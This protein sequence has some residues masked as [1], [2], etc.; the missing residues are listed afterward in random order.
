VNF[1]FAVCE[2]KIL[3][4]DFPAAVLGYQRIGFFEGS[5]ENIWEGNE[6]RRVKIPEGAAIVET[7]NQYVFVEELAGAFQ[8]IRSDLE[9]KPVLTIDKYKRDF[10]RLVT[11]PE[12]SFLSPA[13]VS[14]GQWALLWVAD[15]AEP[16]DDLFFDRIAIGP[17][18]TFHPLILSRE[19][20]LN[21]ERRFPGFPLTPVLPCN[22]EAGKAAVQVCQM[23]KARAGLA[24]QDGE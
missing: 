24:D 1:S 4:T 16:P 10:V 12:H 11:R 5:D 15:S 13:T 20:V 23:L 2:E 8:E 14:G 9:W 3:K 6:N 17:E 19:A 22:S 21:L 18:D 7:A